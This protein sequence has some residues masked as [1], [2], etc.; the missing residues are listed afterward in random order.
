MIP[1]ALLGPGHQRPT[2]RTL[3]RNLLWAC[4][5]AISEAHDEILGARLLAGK[6]APVSPCTA[7][8]SWNLSGWFSAELKWL[9][10]RHHQDLWTRAPTGYGEAELAFLWGEAGTPET[11]RPWPTPE[12]IR[13]MVPPE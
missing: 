1:R 11:I 9:R 6:L 8:A 10:D 5:A 2:S 3:A 7:G 12:Q 13:R 4:D